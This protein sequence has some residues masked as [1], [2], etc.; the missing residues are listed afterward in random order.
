MLVERRWDK[1]KIQNIKQ[2]NIYKY[3]ELCDLLGVEY[4]KATNKKVEILEEFE[5]Y[6]EYESSWI[7]KDKSKWRYIKFNNKRCRND[8]D[9]ARGNRK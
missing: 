2:G 5:R 6:F 4:S 7:K 8:M 9:Y 3:K 1:T